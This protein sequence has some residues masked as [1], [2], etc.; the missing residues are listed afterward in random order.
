[1]D[2]EWPSV[3]RIDREYQPHLEIDFKKMK[4][5]ILDAYKTVQQAGLAPMVAGKPNLDQV[6]E[7]DLEA[8][9]KKFRR[10]RLVFESVRDLFDQLMPA[11]KGA[12]ESLIGQLVAL[13]ERYLDSG[14]V[15]VDP[16]LFYQDPLRQRVIYT[17][18]LSKIVRHL[19]NE[20]QCANTD[21]ITAVLDHRHPIRRASEMLPWYTSR[22]CFK[23]EKSIIN[24]VVLDSTWEAS[25]AYH[26]EHSQNVL[27]WVKNDH[28]G[29]EI[30]YQFNGV[31]R[32]YRPDY[33]V[34]LADGTRLILE[35]KGKLDDEAIAKKAA[36]DEWVEAVNAEGKF[37]QWRYAL[38]DK[39]QQVLDV[40]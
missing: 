4:P 37:G 29:F 15:Q 1:M 22:P 12:K 23:T 13:S 10:Q 18:N 40:L 28:L 19:Y 20:I 5:L 9:A 31:V 2:I 33:L 39:P 26:L 38:C 34:H 14:L 17:L 21:R 6:T 25:E 35:T 11:W 16:P 36:A 27:T 8:L 7:V 32:K 24:M 30:Y 3:I